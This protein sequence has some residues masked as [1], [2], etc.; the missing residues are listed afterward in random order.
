MRAN[1]IDHRGEFNFDDFAGLISDTDGHA[2]RTIVINVL[3]T[4]IWKTR[5]V[6]LI[7]PI[8]PEPDPNCLVYFHT[9]PPKIL[10]VKQPD[11]E[12]LSPDITQTPLLIENA[13]TTEQAAK[14]FGQDLIR[15]III[16]S[17]GIPSHREAI[18]QATDATLAL[19]AKRVDESLAAKGDLGDRFTKTAH[20]IFSRSR[21]A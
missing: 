14:M 20:V 21:P 1:E 2:G 16:K 17:S 13:Q 15:G 12:L 19:A 8:D 10:I 7:L 6:G 18:S 11:N 9:V 4:R 5:T 3:D